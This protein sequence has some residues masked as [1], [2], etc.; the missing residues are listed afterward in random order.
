LLTVE[1]NG[2]VDSITYTHSIPLTYR[3]GFGGI[4]VHLGSLSTI[5]SWYEVDSYSWLDNACSGTIYAAF[6]ATG[7]GVSIV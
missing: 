1:C 3:Q 5:T 6:S 7:T 4:R 2:V